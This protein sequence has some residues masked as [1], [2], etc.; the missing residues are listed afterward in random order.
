MR[1]IKFRAW[2]QNLKKFNDDHGAYDTEGIELNELIRFYQAKNFVLM[3]YTGLK[4]KNG[5]EIYE[6]D[7]LEGFV[8]VSGERRL[9]VVSYNTEYAGFHP[10]IEC[11]YEAA[12]YYVE[13]L[14]IIGNIYENEDLLTNN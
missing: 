3:Q 12:T 11:D 2:D 5:K 7:I 13:P 8:D 4:D 9:Y 14:E 10:F 6:G 1:E